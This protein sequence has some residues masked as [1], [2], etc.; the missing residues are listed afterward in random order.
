MTL[1][2]V[3]TVGEGLGKGTSSVPESPF[4][5]TGLPHI[6]QAW[7]LPYTP[8]LFFPPAASTGFIKRYL[9]YLDY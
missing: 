1:G 6:F 4:L 2:W 7:V 9:G 3:I 8:L 5:P